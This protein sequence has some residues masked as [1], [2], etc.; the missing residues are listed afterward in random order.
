MTGLRGV[1]DPQLDAIFA[2]AEAP[3]LANIFLTGT[4]NIFGDSRDQR[5]AVRA[6]SNAR[7]L[8]QAL[9]QRGAVMESSAETLTQILRDYAM[10]SIASFG[11]NPVGYLDRINAVTEAV[12]D[13]F[14]SHLRSH[15]EE[16]IR[17]RQHREAS[18]GGMSFQDMDSAVSMSDG[19]R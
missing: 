17:D 18:D 7:S 2:Q 4:F 8:A 19:E 15:F 14:D 9:V 6:T 11:E 1:G 5:S 16:A 10:D 3:H 13:S 12:I